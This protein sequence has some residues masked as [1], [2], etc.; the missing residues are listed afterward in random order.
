MAEAV[1][2]AMHAAGETRL[3]LSEKSGIP[4]TTLIRRLNGHSAFTVDELEVIGRVLDV[5]PV[6]FLVVGGAA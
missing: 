6:L 4:R 3:S 1:G 5:D 2:N